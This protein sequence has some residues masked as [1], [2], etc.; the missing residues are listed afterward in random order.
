MKEN[1]LYGALN[2]LKCLLD[3][4]Q[5]TFSC[6]RSSTIDQTKQLCLIM[7]F[8]VFTSSRS[9]WKYWQRSWPP[10]DDVQCT[11]GL[12][13]EL[14]SFFPLFFLQRCVCDREGYFWARWADWTQ[15][16][17]PSKAC[18]SGDQPAADWPLHRLL[19]HLGDDQERPRS[20]GISTWMRRHS[21]H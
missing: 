4:L 6:D 1:F 11:L 12:V 9:W 8:S 18:A 2:N 21:L 19:H 16:G 3:P 13:W 7:L 5:F 17:L 10:C 15:A 20:Q 14:Y